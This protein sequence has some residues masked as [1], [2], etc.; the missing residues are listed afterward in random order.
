M[1]IS[2][3]PLKSI[4][5]PKQQKVY[6]YLN[7]KTTPLHIISSLSYAQFPIKGEMLYSIGRPNS[8]WDL[9]RVLL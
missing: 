4:F 7:L 6:Y 3:D 1:K 8:E 9:I 2:K 5:G